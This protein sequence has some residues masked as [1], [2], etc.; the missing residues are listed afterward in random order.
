MTIVLGRDSIEVSLDSVH[1]PQF[2][3]SHVLF[4]ACFTS[5]TVNDVWAFTGHILTS[6]LA[7]ASISAS[8]TT[9][10]IQNRTVFAIL[11]LAFI[12]CFTIQFTIR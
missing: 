4:L 9:R 8:Y 10:V 2:C 11:S 7:S 12:T 1:T 3:L 5:Y 6:I